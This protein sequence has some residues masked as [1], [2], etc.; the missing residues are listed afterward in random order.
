MKYITSLTSRFGM[1]TLV[2][3]VMSGW[4]VAENPREVPPYGPVT[5]DDASLLVPP[6]GYKDTRAFTIAKTPPTITFTSFR[7]LPRLEGTDGLWSLWGEGIWASNGRYYTGVGDHRGVDAQTYLIEYDPKTNRQ[8]VVV[9]VAKLVNLKPGDYG[10]GKIHGRLDEMADGS[11]FAATY[12]GGHPDNLSPEE[13]KKIG[14]VLFRYDVRKDEAELIDMPLPG[15]SFPMHASDTRRGIF[16]ALGVYGGYVAYDLEKRACLYCVEKLPDGVT[17]DARST[18][19]D[20]KTGRCYGTAM[21]GTRQ[22]IYFDLK[23]M[24]F[25]KTKAF[26]PADPVTDRERPRPFIRAYTRKR[27]GGEFFVA[28]T[29][30]GVTF[31]FFPD[32]ERVEDLGFN[33]ADGL[34]CTSMALSSDDKYIYYTVGAHGSTWESGSPIIQMDTRTWKK[35]VI[36]FLHPT[37]QEEHGYVFGGSYSIALDDKDANLVIA[38]NGN[39]RRAEEK[40]ESFGHPSFMHIAIPE[41]ER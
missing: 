23:D 19:I 33:W 30:D 21:D 28:M 8:R 41:S 37:F 29:Y 11:L 3:H 25:H 7:H 5:C 35:K 17:W 39:F 2:L 40:G 1:V 38:W 6:E 9:D 18:L 12:W 24:A 36:A 10:H 32:E 16:H 34:Y 26:I 15:D 13:K 20:P 22:I 27:I 4:A 31:K 14:G